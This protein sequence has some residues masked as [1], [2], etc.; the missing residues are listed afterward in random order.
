[1]KKIAY[2]ALALTLCA[3]GGSNTMPEA[4]KDFAVEKVQMEKV[5]LT[6]SYPAT[7]KGVQDIEIRPKVAGHIVQVLVD[8]GDFVRAGQ[9]LFVIDKVQYEAA[10]RQ[11]EASVNVAKANVNTQ[12][13]TVDN[14]KYLFD[15]QIISEYDYNVARNQLASLE[16]QLQQANAALISARN[17]L[18]FCTVKSPAN[19][20][21]GTIPYR[22]GSLVSSS[23]TQPLTTV[24]NM[25]QMYVYFSMTEKQLLAMTRA[26]GGVTAA[27]DSLP[28]V[29]LVLADGSTYEK[30]GRVTAISGVI[31]TQT[32]AV[33]M[34]A[35]FDNAGH[36]LRSGGAGNVLIPM[37]MTEALQVPQNAT[38]DIQD[39]KYVYVLGSDKKVQQREITVL[40]Q[41]NGQK[42]VVT[43]GL[44][45]GETI[46]VEGVNQ[47]RGGQEINPI[48]PA[49]SVQNRE[50][51]KQALK[52]GKMPGEN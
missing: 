11:A 22:V 14:K 42:Y 37:S 52:D 9:P 28:E 32:G 17:N 8:E 15:K 19:G 6:T 34:R 13:L 7:L 51:A 30:T 10:V 43:S 2:L 4:S 46:V 36:V 31:D 39:K 1:M 26:Q 38:Y 29:Q 44:K 18:D 16:A 45:A 47:L 41:H 50:K 24:S 35:T 40:S 12:R 33:Q 3:C 5:S 25:N 21:V 48:T 23:G 20:V 49:Q 27:I